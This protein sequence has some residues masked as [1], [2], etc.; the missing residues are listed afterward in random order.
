MTNCVSHG[1]I[2]PA[3]GWPAVH[4]APPT[5]Q[6][7]PGGFSSN[8]AVPSKTISSIQ[9]GT[10]QS[11]LWPEQVTSPL[12]RGDAPLIAAGE[13]GW[14]ELLIQ[15]WSNLPK[16]RALVFPPSPTTTQHTASQDHTTADTR[17]GTSLAVSERLE[18]E[19]S[20]MI[21]RRLWATWTENYWRKFV[22]KVH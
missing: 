1:E 16:I 9:R 14:A 8:P 10:F 17:L 3:H 21:S 11:F 4:P 6:S 5:L 22:Y 20:Q 13:Q 18:S 19:L 2:S 15:H 7:S 12:L